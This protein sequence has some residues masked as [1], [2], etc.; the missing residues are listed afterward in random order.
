M[1]L[2]ITASWHLGRRFH[3]RDCTAVH[4]AA[5]A[6]L[7]RIAR[8]EGAGAILVAGDLHDG[9]RE[10][11]TVA[12]EVLARLVAEAPCPVVV[13]SGGAS[14]PAG[15]LSIGRAVL[16]A[17][18]LHVVDEG[19]DPAEPLWLG[20]GTGGVALHAVPARPG[21]AEALAADVRRAR[22]ARERGEG[23][24]VLALPFRPDAATD[25]LDA[26]DAFDAVVVGGEDEPSPLAGV[27]GPG[28][29][30]APGA[31]WPATLPDVGHDRGAATLLVGADGEARVTRHVLAGPRVEAVA[32]ALETLEDARPSSGFVVARLTDPV[33]LPRG[34]ARLAIARRDVIAVER[35]PSRRGL[36]PAEL[37]DAWLAERG[38]ARLDR[39]DRALLDGLM[40]E[41]M[42]GASTP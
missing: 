13:L 11:E 28:G 33:P 17:A 24:A 12:E 37:V 22:T 2:L 30:V 41:S 42:A 25:D 23:R 6:S 36:S 40:S 27:L 10:G 21:G 7:A 32:G 16:A 39:E 35:R 18:G 38:G 34:A 20:E 4:S 14:S 3:G 9:T 1:R 15:R 26:F 19:W 29:V 5:L 31:P 8:D